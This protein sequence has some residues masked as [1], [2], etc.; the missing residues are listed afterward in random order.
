MMYDP[1]AR[2]KKQKQGGENGEGT[3]SGPDG[4]GKEAA[5]RLMPRQ[6]LIVMLSTQSS[7]GPARKMCCPHFAKRNGLGRRGK[8]VTPT[9]RL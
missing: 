2:R 7:E 8:Q 1:G 6:V 5:T 4:A 3:K 9:C